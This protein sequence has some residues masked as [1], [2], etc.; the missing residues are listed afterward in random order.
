MQSERLT[1]PVPGST[2]PATNRPNGASESLTNAHGH[3][4]EPATL[5]AKAD[6]DLREVASQ[7]C[8][9]P[10]DPRVK[11]RAVRRLER[12]T[13]EGTGPDSEPMRVRPWMIALPVLSFVLATVFLV[14]FLAGGS[15]A[16][17]IILAAIGFI[18]LSNAPLIGAIWL[19][20]RDK[21]NVERTVDE[22]ARRLSREHFGPAANRA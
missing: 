4:Q 1:R 22:E 6:L 13:P 16:G 8:C 20:Q 9:S 3:R 21:R 7:E 14:W 11:E 17:F 18:I 12:A 10:E 2:P 5:R 15:T 19:R